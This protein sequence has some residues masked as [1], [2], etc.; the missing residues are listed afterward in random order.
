MSLL[1][2][3]GERGGKDG[4]LKR[5]TLSFPNDVALSPDV[6]HSDYADGGIPW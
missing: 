1:V 3:T 2:G 5:A 4:G 6:R